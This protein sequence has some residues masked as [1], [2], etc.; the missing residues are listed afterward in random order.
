MAGHA[1][2]LGQVDGKATQED[3]TEMSEGDPSFIAWPCLAVPF[4]KQGKDGPEPQQ[5]Y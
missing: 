3:K 2:K 1:V 5:I 4:R